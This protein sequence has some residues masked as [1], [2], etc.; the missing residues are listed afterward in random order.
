MDDPTEEVD[1]DEAPGPV[2]PDRA[3]GELRMGVDDE[4]DVAVAH[5][6]NSGSM[7]AAASR[8]PGSAGWDSSS[9][10]IESVS[11]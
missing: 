11:S 4:L 7:K 10:S 1:P 5:L 8:T 6:F 9:F 3:L 2:V